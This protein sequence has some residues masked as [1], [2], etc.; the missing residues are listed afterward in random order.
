MSYEWVTD[1]M[2]DEELI[3]ILRDIPSSELLRIPGT[4]EILKEEFNDEVL[5]NLEKNRSDSFDEED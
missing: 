2:F 3:A 4:Y 5:S 1:E